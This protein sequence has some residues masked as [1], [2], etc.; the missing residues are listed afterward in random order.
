MSSLHGRHFRPSIIH[1]Y[2]PNNPYE[3]KTHYYP[4]FTDKETRTQKLAQG[5]TAGERW[6]STEPGHSVCQ[7]KL[8]PTLTSN[9]TRAHER[10]TPGLDQLR[11]LSSTSTLTG[12]EHSFRNLPFA[13][14]VGL[15]TW[16][17]G[18]H[19]LDTK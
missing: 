18:N 14:S 12:K 19:N 9:P 1:F 11:R 10:N 13:A 2:P 8:S 17:R 3:V 7:L 4:H 16:G 6:G 15:G 5:H